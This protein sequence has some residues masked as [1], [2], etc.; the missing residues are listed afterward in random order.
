MQK[1]GFLLLSHLFIWMIENT[2]RTSFKMETTEQVT[3]ESL[4]GNLNISQHTVNLIGK[5]RNNITKT[6]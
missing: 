5:Q 3:T 2:T 6:V 4:V 1:A